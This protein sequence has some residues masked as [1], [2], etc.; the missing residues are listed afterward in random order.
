MLR[1]L[2]IFIIFISLCGYCLWYFPN[3]IVDKNYLHGTVIEII[4]NETDEDNI[5]QL[6]VV[7]VKIEE[8]LRA[9]TGSIGLIFSIPITSASYLFFRK[10][11]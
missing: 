2:C 7:N 8:V 11:F 4:D 5:Q 6:Q 9:F 10:K 3:T 1:K